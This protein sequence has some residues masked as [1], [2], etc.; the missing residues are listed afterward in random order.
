MGSNTS[1]FAAAAAAKPRSPPMVTNAAAA[2]A[3]DD[4]T[5]AG[6]LKE[7]LRTGGGEPNLELSSRPGCK[8]S[9][10]KQELQP[11]KPCLSFPK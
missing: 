2:A 10:W 11:I 9:A 8:P 7:R 5:D 6:L 1:T 3:A 4:V